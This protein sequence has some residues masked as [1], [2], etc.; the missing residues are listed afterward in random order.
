MEKLVGEF[1]DRGY[2]AI[3]CSHPHMAQY[4]SDDGSILKVVD[5]HNVESEIL[6]RYADKAW[7]P[8][9]KS[10]ARLTAAKL[11]K[12]ETE[13]A[14]KFDLCTAV[15]KRD[16][17]FFSK[18]GANVAVIEN[19]VDT[20]YFPFKPNTPDEPTLTFTGWMKYH[21]NDEAASFFCSQVFPL[22]QKN[23]PEVRFTIVGKDPSKEVLRC[24]DRAGVEVTGFVPDVRPYLYGSSVFVVP[25]LVGGGT[26]LKILEAMSAGVPVV[27]TSVGCEGLDVEQ[28]RHLLVADSP[29]E[30]AQKTLSLMKDK[31]IRERIAGEARALVEE[32]YG[33]N[34]IGRK[35]I[36]TYGEL[37]G[38]GEQ[39]AALI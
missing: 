14:C 15:S 31:T 7:D 38:A 8:L 5:M 28:G 12:Y 2:D 32:K 19:G 35:L 23:I 3:H 9:R 29:E 1:L 24:A 4:S 26:R 36:D 17:E 13:C 11:E 10:Y 16:A 21:A 20:D 33:W 25:L 30:F 37:S 39:K 22:I 6:N 27:S 18:R 34:I